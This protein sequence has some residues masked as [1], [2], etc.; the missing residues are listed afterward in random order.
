TPTGDIALGAGS[1]GGLTGGAVQGTNDYGK[2]GYG[3]PCPPAG[4][5][6]HHYQF[7]LYALKVPDLKAA[8]GIPDN[9][10]GGLVGFAT[11]ANAT[12]QAS[13]TATYGR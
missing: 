5:A 10:T 7:T 1:P 6:A 4:A 8:A 12:A 9:A 3:G 11:R 2:T 13:F